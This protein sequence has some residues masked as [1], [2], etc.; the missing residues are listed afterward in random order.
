MCVHIVLMKGS[1]KIHR[2]DFIT[3]FYYEKVL[4]RNASLC[5]GGGGCRGQLPVD[6]IQIL[7]DTDLL[8]M[9]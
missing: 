6:L 3:N 7:H 9:G 4:D 8:A 2:I 5:S 1:V